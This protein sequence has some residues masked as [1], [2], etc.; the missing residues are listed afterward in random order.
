LRSCGTAGKPAATEKTNINLYH[1]KNPVY[2]PKVGR[3]SIKNC[4]AQGGCLRQ[5]GIGER[6]TLR[7][8]CL[9]VLEP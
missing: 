5:A 1:L 7:K 8:D 9:D 4:I 2:S 6:K 3:I